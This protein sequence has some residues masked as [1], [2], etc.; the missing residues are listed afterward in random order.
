MLNL[1]I[2]DWFLSDEAGVMFRYG[3]EGEQ[4]QKAPE[5]AMAND[6]EQAWYELLTA[7]VW[8]EPSQNVI[9]RNQLMNY[10]VAKDHV[11][12][13]SS[14]F[15]YSPSADIVNW[16]LVGEVNYEWLP[17]LNLDKDLAGELE[18][19]RAA[20]Q[21]HALQNF[22]L[23]VLGYRSMDEWD[24]YVNELHSIGSDRYVEIAQIGYDE[25]SH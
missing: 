18:E 10:A 20:L 1:R 24:A 17:Q 2:M 15:K 19:L 9:W 16:N 12:A 5:G 14:A 8:S 3:F 25:L 11:S 21:D 23:F 4:W 6:G 7:E 22:S 13:G